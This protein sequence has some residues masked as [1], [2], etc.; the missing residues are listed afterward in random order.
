MPASTDETADIAASRPTCPAWCVSAHGHHLGE[1]D[2]VHS[3][4]PL[5]IADGVLAHGCMSVDPLTGAVDGPYVIVGW[6]QYTP[7]EAEALGASL[8]AMA[9][10]VA[11]P[12]RA[13]LPNGVARG[14]SRRGRL[15]RGRR[16]RT[17]RSGWRL[18]ARP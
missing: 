12:A 8:V 3:G 1:E 9:R 18:R 5:R 17:C 7:E 10:A 2:W 11:G 13:R 15:R 14:G 16:W 4:E 6:E